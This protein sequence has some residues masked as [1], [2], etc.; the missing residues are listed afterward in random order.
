MT[1]DERKLYIAEKM[2]KFYNR[3]ESILFNPNSAMQEDGI[4]LVS[5][6][7]DIISEIDKLEDPSSLAHV[8][9]RLELAKHRLTQAMMTNTPQEG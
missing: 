6:V 5:E 3:M 2:M 8:R 1:D 9:T 7:N 4:K